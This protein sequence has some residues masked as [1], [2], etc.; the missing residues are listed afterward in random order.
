MNH[1]TNNKEDDE[2]AVTASKLSWLEE[3][4][5]GTTDK[6]EK[7]SIEASIL[8]AQTEHKQAL[9]KGAADARVRANNGD[10]NY[11]NMISKGVA[12]VVILDEDDDNDHEM[13]TENNKRVNG[14]ENEKTD[15][16]KKS[17][18]DEGEWTVV[19]PKGV[20]NGNGEAQGKGVSNGNGG[21]QGK[22]KGNKVEEA[23]KMKPKKL[24][25]YLLT[26]TQT[27]PLALCTLLTFTV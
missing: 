24:I 10:E 20:A 11:T 23:K 14:E 2:V 26:P 19:V 21:A 6:E 18:V 25:D 8:L 13:S 7:K 22:G 1:N 15:N 9:I 16:E 17:K 3:K 4:L 5:A 12:E 27:S